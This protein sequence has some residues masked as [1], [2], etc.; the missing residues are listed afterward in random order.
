M[1]IMGYW[2]S[3]HKSLRNNLLLMYTTN[4]VKIKLRSKHKHTM[5]KKKKR[6]QENLEENTGNTQSPV[7][8]GIHNI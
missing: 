7:F 5:K 2:S 3:I 6:I 4:P 1:C 8:L